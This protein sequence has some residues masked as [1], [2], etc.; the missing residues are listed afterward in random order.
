VEAQIVRLSRGHKPQQ[1]TRWDLPAAQKVQSR[2][3]SFV[4]KIK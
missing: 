3:R 4:R 2:F 1:Q